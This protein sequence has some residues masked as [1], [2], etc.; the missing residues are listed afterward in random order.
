MTNEDRIRAEYFE[1]EAQRRSVE[2]E[3][4]QIAREYGGSVGLTPAQ[5]EQLLARGEK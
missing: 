3:F 5:M 4:E 2:R 1:S